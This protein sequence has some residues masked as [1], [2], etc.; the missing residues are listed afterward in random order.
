MERFRQTS[1]LLMIFST[2]PMLLAL[3]VPDFCYARM[4][5]KSI[6][7]EGGEVFSLTIDPGNS[8]II[9]AGTNNGGVSKS[10]NGGSTWSPFNSG[11]SETNVAA[12]A[13]HPQNSI[14]IYLSTRGG[15][16]KSLIEQ[17]GDFDGDGETDIAVYR[18]NTG[19][20]YIKPSSGGAPYGVGWGGDSSE[21]PVAGDYDGDGKA[22]LAIYR[23]NIGAWFIYPSKTGPSGIYGVGFGGDISDMPVITNPGSYM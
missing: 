4:K 22:D 6:G 12:I 13:I 9:Y 19:A 8:S 10:I 7:P 21:K 11:R 15:V 3:F 2:L 23:S 17:I 1:F 18:T 16:F 20:W 14:K 5:W